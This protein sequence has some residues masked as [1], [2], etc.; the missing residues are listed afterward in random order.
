MA[1]PA[2]NVLDPATGAILFSF[3]DELGTSNP[4]G[5]ITRIK[6]EDFDLGVPEVSMG[7]LGTPNVGGGIL[8]KRETLFAQ[9]TA[10]V[11]A[12]GASQGELRLATGY[13]A[14]VLET[15]G[16]IS[17]QPDAS[18]AVSFIDYL[19]SNE[20]P[21]LY[22]DG[23]SVLQLMIGNRAIPGF[24][25][26][27][28]RQPHI[29]T[30]PLLASVNK[31]TN[32]WPLREGSTSGRP[33]GWTLDS[34]TGITNESIDNNGAHFTVATTGTRNWSETTAAGSFAPGDIA[35]FAYDVTASAPSIARARAAVQFKQSDGTTNVGSEFT[36]TLTPVTSGVTRVTV[37]TTAA[38]ALTSRAF[39]SIRF[40]NV[41]ATAVD[42]AWQKAQAETGSTASEYRM[43][44]ETLSNDPAGF[45]VLP[46]WNPGDA[47]ARSDIVVGNHSIDWHQMLVAQFKGQ[48]ST[49]ADFVNGGFLIPSSNA[50][51]GLEVADIDTT[52]ST[53]LGATFS[54]DDAMTTTFSV[55][56]TLLARMIFNGASSSQQSLVDLPV[57]VFGR[58]ATTNASGVFQAQLDVES[59]TPDTVSFSLQTANTLYELFLGIATL[60]STST[61][62]LSLARTAGTGSLRTDCLYMAPLDALSLVDSTSNT[63]LKLNAHASNPAV[64][65]LLTDSAVHDGAAVTQGEIP[66]IP[67]GLSALLLRMWRPLG[68]G[69]SVEGEALAAKPKP[70]T[71]AD[72]FTAWTDI[73]PQRYQ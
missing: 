33:L 22:R 49:L 12:Q 23:P 72:T 18:S 8:T 20:A 15:P 45:C 1:Y 55:V 43:G 5:I 9:T 38:G 3:N 31:L 19:G 53:G 26:S 25:V 21:S 68:S 50:A 66:V 64:C 6:D 24:M 2:I 14:R 36:G 7:T 10:R 57:A 62:D 67:P 32:S 44:V 61:W 52:R 17:W 54:E 51:F 4:Q 35:T 46:V 47:D 70:S 71:L 60:R 42:V 30:Q 65:T 27:L 34:A 40:E 41:A 58:F 59:G 48:G 13:L 11:H 56:P 16:V 69:L 39:V 37:T 63:A 29:R 73:I 28:L